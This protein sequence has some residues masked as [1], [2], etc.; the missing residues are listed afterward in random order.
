[1]EQL[2]DKII[3]Y[4]FGVCL[5]TGSSHFVLPVLAALIALTYVSLFICW[6]K[7]IRKIILMLV[8]TAFTFGCKE[9]AFFVPLL[10]YD[11]VLLRKW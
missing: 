10:C 2:T 7:G 9:L 1:M 3:I 11:S 5:M 8:F 6:E 4:I